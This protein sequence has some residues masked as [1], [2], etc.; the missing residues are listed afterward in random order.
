MS[1]R[2]RSTASI[3]ASAFLVLALAACSDAPLAS[4]PD[5]TDAVFAKQ[6]NSSQ[7]FT[8]EGVT[9]EDGDLLVES[10]VVE[11]AVKD[12]R[13]D[14]NDWT[15]CTYFTEDWQESL[16]SHGEAVVP[17]DG[18]AEAVEAFCVDNFE[19]RQ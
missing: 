18:S 14:K 8:F 1:R 16:G 13:N 19:N 5:G 9:L 17:G 6:G 11:A 4:A 3:L 15:N 10:G 12:K 2:I 7:K